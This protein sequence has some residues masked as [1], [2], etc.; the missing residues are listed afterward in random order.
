LGKRKK[1]LG[2]GKR[3]I[4]KG[5]GEKGNRVLIAI[6]KGKGIGEEGFG[7]REKRKREL[8]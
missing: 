5:I 8:D 7:K 3:E 4:G 2:L 6:G 1:G